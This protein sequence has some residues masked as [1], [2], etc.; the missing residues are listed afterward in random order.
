MSEAIRIAGQDDVPALYD[1]LQQAYAPLVSEGVHFTITRSPVERV[2]HTV[3]SH[4][5]FVLVR[6]SPTGSGTRL[7]ATLTVR[8]PWTQG[9]RHLSP[10][11]FLHWFA[12]APEYKRQGLGSTLLEHVE[13]NFL[14]AQV[15][16]PAAYL[17]TAVEHPWLRPYYERLGYSPFHRSTN[18]LGTP[19]VWLRKILI[20]ELYHES[21][22]TSFVPSS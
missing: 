20:P 13:D 9:D 8:F 11:P 15:K 5:T 16:A 19:L 21:V 2:F 12:V 3:A 4:T 7:A 17:A 18:V 14:K 6:P 22:P 1:L 10:Y